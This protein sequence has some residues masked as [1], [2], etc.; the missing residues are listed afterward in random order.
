MKFKKEFSDENDLIAYQNELIPLL[1]DAH[2]AYKLASKHQETL[3]TSLHNL[4]LVLFYQFNPMFIN[5][6]A[7]VSMEDINKFCLMIEKRD[8]ANKAKPKAK[9]AP[10][11]PTPQTQ[12]QQQNQ[13]QTPQ[14]SASTSQ[15]FSSQ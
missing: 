3:C 8:K 2:E 9:P 6:N 13:T 14:V 4:L 10:Q 1:L 5:N 15:I 12:P 11:Q 7:R